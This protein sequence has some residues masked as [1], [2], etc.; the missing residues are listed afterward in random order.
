MPS[1]DSQIPIVD[2]SSSNSNA[3]AELL[4]AAA[5]CGFVFVENNSAGIPARDIDQI[6]ELSKQ[7]FDSPNEVKES[8]AISSNKAGKNHGWVGGGVENL[9]LA[10]GGDLKE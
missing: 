9:D 1:T 10:S 5:S 2:I 3:A 8:V 4:S 7:F 6:F